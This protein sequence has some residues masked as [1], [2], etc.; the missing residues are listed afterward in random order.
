MSSTALLNALTLQ[1]AICTGITILVLGIVGNVLNILVFL[2]LKTFRENS[3]AFYLTAMSF[4][5]LGQLL[6]SALPRLMN[7]CFSIDW[8]SSSLFYCKF[9]AYCFQ[10]CSLASF[11]CMCLATIDQYLTTS[12][13]FWWQRWSS[14]KYAHF[15]FAISL[16]IWILHGIPVV[17]FFRQVP[18]ASTGDIVCIITNSNFQSYYTYGFTLILLSSLPVGVTALFGSLAYRNVTRLAFRTVPLVRRELDKQLTVMVLVQVV[19]TFVVIVPYIVVYMVNLSITV[20]R[21]SYGYAQLQLA[22]NITISL[23]Y[24]YSAVRTSRCVKRMRSTCLICFRVL[25]TSTSACRNDSADSSSML[26]SGCI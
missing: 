2:S 21:D 10:V 25:S 26:S 8:S 9:R 17:V 23:Y 19:F 11:T 6:T 5:N 7:M 1:W 18:S 12:T 24:V 14:V 3:C 4:L 13:Y 15:F 16:V 22:R 20:S